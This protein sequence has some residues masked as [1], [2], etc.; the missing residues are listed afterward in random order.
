MIQP[1]HGDATRAYFAPMRPVALRSA[2][3]QHADLL[4]A[5]LVLLAYWPLAS[6]QNALTDGDTMNCW[7]PWRWSIATSLHDAALPWWNPL[8]QM[9][10]PMHADLQGPAWYVEAIALAGT[11]GMGPAVLQVLFLG[12]VIIGGWGMRRLALHLT[13]HEDG[14]LLAG[15]AYALS[16][17]FTAHT[18]HFYAI[19]S[20]AWLPWAFWSVLRGLDAPGWRNS[21]LMAVF[22]HLLITG[23]NHTFLLIAAYPLMALVVHGLWQSWRGG[24]LTLLRPIVVHGAAAILLIALTS[25]GTLHAVVEVGD[26][27][28][29]LGGL[30]LA[31]AEQN[32]MTWSGLASA[33]L[34]AM[35]TAHVDLLGTD[36]TM[37]N[38]FFG[39]LPL[40][41][42]LLAL[43][44]VR[45]GRPV[46]FLAT[47]LLSGLA[48][49]G[50]A[51]PLHGLLWRFLP[52]LDLFRFPSY[53]WYFVSLGLLPWAAEGLH[54]LHDP[55]YRRWMLYGVAGLSILL[56]T[57]C[58]HLFL[59]HPSDDLFGHVLTPRSATWPARVLQNAVVVVL[60]LVMTAL[61]LA[62]RW[63]R[64]W[65]L[66]IIAVEGLAAVH[67][68]SW[69]TSLH[70]A[71]P[72]ALQ[73]RLDL[74]P[75][76]PVFPVLHPMGQDRDGAAAIHPFWLNTR[77][78]Q[79]G[80]SHDGFNS[81]WLKG[82]QTLTRDH[83][84]LH[85]SMLQRPWVS[86][87]DDVR[88]MPVDGPPPH[89]TIADRQV[90]WIPDQQASIPQLALGSGPVT[91]L[92]AY[93]HQGFSVRTRTQGPSFLLVQ[94]N[95]YPGWVVKVDGAAVPLVPANVAAFGAFVPAGD[96][97]VDVRYERPTLRWVLIAGHGILFVLLLALSWSSALRWPW[98]MATV[99][100]IGL[101]S[102]SVFAH[103]PKASRI[104]GQW[105]EVEAALAAWSTE[106]VVVN[107]DRP[108]PDGPARRLLRMDAP[109]E[110]LALEQQIGLPVPDKLACAWHGLPLSL[111]MR[112]FLQ[113]NYAVPQLRAGGADAGAWLLVRGSDPKP[114]VAVHQVSEEQV[115]VSPERSYTAAFRTRV[116]ELMGAGHEHLVIDLRYRCNGGAEPRLV[117]ERKLGDRTVDYEA[118]SLQSPPD[119]GVFHAAYIVRPLDLFPVSEE[120]LGFY[121]W[122]A[123]SDTLWVKDIRVR[124]GKVME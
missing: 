109:D 56:I 37:A 10:Y 117:L 41:L 73:A 99:V 93:D 116:G 28:E 13:G 105:A 51:T 100:L 30:S 86:L 9:G 34:P 64:R 95:L 29:R 62:R 90:V 32:P 69:S 38:A 91:E 6:F 75:H 89:D 101:W 27:V 71:P 25:A 23:G 18:M 120:E 17:F 67:F 83:P 123:S 44:F 31:Q 97:V 61:V 63:D 96:H 46:I 115:L 35:A 76:G 74:Q 12:Y 119:D 92:A 20:A 112:A 55:R 15:L 103:V 43:S 104:A 21:A 79:N 45:G 84:L 106:P 59:Q 53:Y 24:G 4:I 80:P 47:A 5:L 8:Q 33:L 108:L 1:I 102:W 22:F 81:F 82:H 78:F 36:P 122:N 14:A 57:A 66:L 54:R 68:T 94:Q 85:A 7:L 111:S 49:L 70:E 110:V 3:V 58:I 88:V 118:V 52:G 19:I 77:N 11:I 48:A 107:T 2:L 87:S 16:G 121:L 42:A 114:L 60:L 26:H 98:I 113:D 40:V 65:L 72:S 39:L 124:I 50:A